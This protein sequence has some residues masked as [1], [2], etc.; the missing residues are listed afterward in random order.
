MRPSGMLPVLVADGALTGS[1]IA[2]HYSEC[3]SP[4]AFHSRA[5]F[6]MI[7]ISKANAQGVQKVAIIHPR[8]APAAAR[9][10]AFFSLS[11]LFLPMLPLHSSS[12]FSLR[13]EL[14]SFFVL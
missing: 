5:P 1:S 10:V 11:E 6:A 9:A 3:Q 4:T 13:A 8:A 14:D 2:K 7:N 12:H